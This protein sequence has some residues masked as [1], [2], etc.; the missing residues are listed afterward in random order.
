MPT[1]PTPG[2]ATWP[3]ARK[4]MDYL[5]ARDANLPPFAFRDADEREWLE[6]PARR[7]VYR[8]VPG[9]AERARELV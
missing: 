2:C 1:P 7:C 4:I 3:S 5:R 9:R 8:R 6:A